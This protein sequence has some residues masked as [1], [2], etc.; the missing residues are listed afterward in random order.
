MARLKNKD[1]NK[2]LD[3]YKLKR[4]KTLKMKKRVVENILAKKLCRCIKKVTSKNKKPP[5][6]IAICKNSVF[7]KKGVNPYRF[8]CK[9]KP[10]LY[11]KKGTKKMRLSLKSS[12]S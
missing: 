9:K 4:P 6:A 2:I 7:H 11:S 3:F 5:Q 10:K 1:Y 8:T 12:F